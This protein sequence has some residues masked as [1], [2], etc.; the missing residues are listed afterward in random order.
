M[1]DSF[2]DV[3]GI[4]RTWRFHKDGEEKNAGRFQQYGL[5]LPD[6][7]CH[8][9]VSRMCGLLFWEKSVKMEAARGGE[10]VCASGQKSHRKE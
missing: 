6:E 2:T 1:D 4:G 8:G 7:E 5:P 3:S 9:G 10:T